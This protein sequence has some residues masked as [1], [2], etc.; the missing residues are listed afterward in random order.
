MMGSKTK[1]CLVLWYHIRTQYPSMLTFEWPA[2][3]LHEEK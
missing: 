1:K 2:D 3:D